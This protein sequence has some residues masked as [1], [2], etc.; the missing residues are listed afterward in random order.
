MIRIIAVGKMKDRRLADLVSEY[1]RRSTGMAPCELVEVRDSNPEREAKAMVQKLGSPAGSGLVIALDEHG[2]ETT[3][4]G[5]AELLGGH[6]SV[7]FLVG[8]A[9]GLGSAARQRADRTL[10]LSRL[11]LTHEMARL[12]L[13]EQIYR[14]L[15]IL[16]GKPYHRE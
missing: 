13:V 6:G 5:L 7:A 11:T 14:G 4:R 8:G 2:D 1:W 3:S 16:R 12:L 9:D 10:R 15:T